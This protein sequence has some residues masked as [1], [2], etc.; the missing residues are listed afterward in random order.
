MVD[1]AS[2]KMQTNI[3]PKSF[4]AVKRFYQNNNIDNNDRVMCRRLSIVT[5]DIECF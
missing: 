5:I 1:C 3:N 4:I 2:V